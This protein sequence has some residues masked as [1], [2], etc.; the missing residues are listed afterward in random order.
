[1]KYET[2]NRSV[3][4]DKFILGSANVH[5]VPQVNRAQREP[6]SNPQMPKS[7]PTWVN[8]AAFVSFFNSPLFRNRIL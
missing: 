6:V 8:A 3:S 5:Q 7:I 2:N 1:M 4:A